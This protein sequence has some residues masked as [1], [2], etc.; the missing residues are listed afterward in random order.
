MKV[1]YT[2]TSRGRP[3]GTTD[4]GFRYR[5][6]ASRIGWFQPNTDG[7]RLMPVVSAVTATT[8]VYAQSIQRRGHSP[9]VGAREGDAT[10]LADVA[11]ACQHAGALDLELHAEDGT[12]IPTEIVS[13]Q[14]TEELLAWD[15]LEEAIEWGEAWKRGDRTFDSLCGPTDDSFDQELDA[16]EREHQFDPDDDDAVI[17]GDGFADTLDA[18]TPDEYE[19]DPMMRYQI[20]VELVDAGA[21]P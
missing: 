3:I 7:E 14:D 9:G 2:I 12:L 10:L 17:F 8:R 1:Q 15:D 6:G 13:I 4:L 18:W 20:F 5:P 16:D 19:P 21:I 11:E